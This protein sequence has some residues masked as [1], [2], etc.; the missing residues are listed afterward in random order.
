MESTLY[1]RYTWGIDVPVIG[2]VLSKTGCIGRVVFGIYDLTD[3]SSA[4]RFAQ[5]ILG[6]QTHVKRIVEQCSRSTFRLFSWRLDSID[7][8][9][10]TEGTWERRIYSWLSDIPRPREGRSVLTPVP[11]SSPPHLSPNRE[12]NRS[13]S[14]TPSSHQ[15]SS[16]STRS[17]SLTR[18]EGKPPSAQRGRTADRSGSKRRSTSCSVLGRKA[19]EGIAP[20]NKLSWGSYSHD[21][22]IISVAAIDLGANRRNDTVAADEINRMKAV[23][24][25]LT[26]YQAPPWE[27][28]EDMP[29]VDERMTMIRDHFFD[30]M[31]SCPRDTTLCTEHIKT[32]ADT[33]SSLCWASVGGFSKMVAQRETN[34][35]E[36]GHD[37]DFLMYLMYLS[38][39]AINPSR[40]LLEHT[41]S[42]SQN[43]V[44]DS[45][46]QP[47]FAQSFMTCAQESIDLNDRA[48]DSA[49]DKFSIR[50]D[51]FLQ[52]NEAFTV[53]LTHA[54]AV[55]RLF[56]S[57]TIH[58]DI[59]KRADIE[60]KT[61][62][63]DI[64]LPFPLDTPHIES[65]PLIEVATPK[66]E[67]SN[68]AN[69]SKT[70]N[71]W[72]SVSGPTKSK[73][74][75]NLANI[76]EA[77][78]SSEERE[79]L[80]TTMIASVAPKGHATPEENDPQESQSG[81]LQNPCSVNCSET[82]GAKPLP[83]NTV[84]AVQP[85]V[86]LLLLAVLVGEYRK[87]SD[88]GFLK[89]LIQ[90]KI[91]IEASC[92]H[93]ASL[94]I[95]DH[96]V[97][98]LATNG[99]EGAVL[100]GWYSQAKDVIYLMERNVRTFNISSPIQVYHFATFILR[101]RDYSQAVLKKKALEALGNAAGF[102]QKSWTKQAQN[103]RLGL[104]TGTPA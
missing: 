103:D 2:I 8:Q 72:S 19:V 49:R 79:E 5:F 62:V 12:M 25:Q 60:P 90:T 3:P 86:G 102:E 18:S 80:M 20:T 28:I 24:D 26:G 10:G 1:Q 52:A 97:F 101:L 7:G 64:I 96:P 9:C 37:W 68:A 73:S 45:F 36:A 46:S 82:K 75:R 58:I 33:F 63:C 57:K 27:S 43:I 16:H 15:H 92:R 69:G 70:G 89:A 76:Q 44:V 32:I 23:Y 34:G 38:Q 78:S 6:L 30:Q 93:L 29:S 94:G 21:R 11:V 95:T 84:N 14:A 22:K 54:R 71:Y 56:K 13:R 66:S 83:S 48:A 40:P 88:S 91:Y 100:M 55:D 47:E 42:L 50:S 41:I 17:R 81:N 51:V 87:Y 98:G 31:Q 59:R 35:A 85:L 67:D 104:D 74:S 77:R 53:S 39:S 61:A 4:L 65:E 99:C